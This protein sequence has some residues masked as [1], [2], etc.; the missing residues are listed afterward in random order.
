VDGLGRTLRTVDPNEVTEVIT[1][2][3]MGRAVAKDL[4]TATGMFRMREWNHHPLDWPAWT[5]EV[6]FTY[7]T[8]SDLGVA[9][10]AYTVTDGLGRT[11]QSWTAESG[12]TGF[13]VSEAL[14]DLSG[15]TVV[16]RAPAEEVAFAANAPSLATPGATDSRTYPDAL[17]TVRLGWTPAAGGVLTTTPTLREVHATDDAG[18]VH[19][20][21]SDRTGR[22]V[23]VRQGDPTAPVTTGRYNWD[24]RDR[25]RTLTDANGNSILYDYDQVGRLRDVLRQPASGGAWETWASYTHDGPLPRTMIDAEGAEAVAWDYDTLGRVTT[26]T[27]L[28]EGVPTTSTVLWDTQWK[29]ARSLI[30]DPIVTTEYTIDGTWGLGFVGEVKR[31]WLDGHTAEWKHTLDSDGAALHSELP[32]SVTVSASVTDTRWT[33]AYTVATPTGS[34]DVELRPGDYGQ[35]VGGYTITWPGFNCPLIVDET[36]RVPGQPDRIDLQRP[37]CATN[38]IHYDFD[39]GGRLESRDYTGAGLPA[40]LWAYTYDDLGRIDSVAQDGVLLE[41]ILR[42]P[43]GLPIEVTRDTAGAPPSPVAPLDASIWTY[44]AASR[45]GEI[46]TRK[47]TLGDLA[48]T[49]SYTWDAMGRLATTHHKEPEERAWERH[50]YDGFGR[51]SKTDGM[52]RRFDPVTGDVDTLVW[53]HRNW[54]DTEDRLVHEVRTGLAPK[55]VH[56]APG[57]LHDTSVGQT[58]DALPMLRVVDGRPHVAVTEASGRAAWVFDDAGAERSHEAVGATGVALHQTGARW[59]QDG[60]HG[61]QPDLQTGLVNHGVRHAR[62]DDGLWLQPEPLLLLGPTNGNLA[63]PLAYGPA[64]AAGDTNTLIDRSGFAP[65]RDEYGNPIALEGIGP[66]HTNAGGRIVAETAGRGWFA[67]LGHIALVR[68]SSVSIP[69]RLWMAGNQTAT[70]A[71]HVATTPGAGAAANGVADGVCAVVEQVESALAEVVEGVGSLQV[72]LDA[73]AEAGRAIDK[74]KHTKAGR[75]LAKHAGREGSNFNMPERTDPDSVN[76]AGQE[77][78]EEILTNS[79]SKITELGRGGIQVRKPNGSGVRFNADGSMSGFI[80]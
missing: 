33:E 42:D 51:L 29:G 75:A 28:R 47:G 57:Y 71:A 63:T 64:Y 65:P 37:D 15:N 58:I 36:L 23:E 45:F 4:L 79:E 7:E 68:M 66:V 9:R 48:V 80:D 50:T 24:A 16:Q 73:M 67:E 52:E 40:G 21:V 41:T 11:F 35:P 60:L 74:G 12:P 38:A 30:E 10:S 78:L 18:R 61:S 43:L 62:L 76:A 22:L 1:Y 32:G 13:T 26:T 6:R 55:T 44:D 17:G 54:Y 5:E 25:L 8:P 77:A 70:V 56:R 14:T 72:D 31:T 39:P 27:V 19:T 53:T 20:T 46:A 59:H 3:A 34:V 49:D 69:L 2:D